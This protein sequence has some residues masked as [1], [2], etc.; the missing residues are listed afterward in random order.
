V[1]PLTIFYWY[2]Y[3]WWKASRCARNIFLYFA[4]NVCQDSVVDTL[5]RLRTGPEG[6]RKFFRLQRFDT[7]C[8]PHLAFHSVDTCDSFAGSNVACAWNWPLT[9]IRC[10]TKDCSDTP[11][12]VYR[13]MLG[14]FLRYSTVLCLGRDSLIGVTTRYGHTQPSIQWLLCLSRG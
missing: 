1:A 10:R 11:L 9:C 12:S 8:G 14:S 2:F 7:G 13:F 4:M 3:F 5:T 6:E